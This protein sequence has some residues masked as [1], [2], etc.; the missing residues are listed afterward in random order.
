MPSKLGHSIIPRHAN[1]N[2]NTNAD[3]IVEGFHL[4][5][6]SAIKTDVGLVTEGVP[7]VWINRTD[8]PA[9]PTKLPAFTSWDD[10]I[11]Y[12]VNSAHNSTSALTT[13]GA[14]GV[15]Q[16]NVVT[17]GPATPGI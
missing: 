4:N 7:S 11:A 10:M 2:L 16:S 15:A 12:I 9:F 5:I 14:D 17:S 6:T 1:I 3:G 13:L 8:M